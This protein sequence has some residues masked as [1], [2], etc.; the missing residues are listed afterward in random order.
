M[1]TIK[2]MLI[3]FAVLVVVL[4]AIPV[5]ASVNPPGSVTDHTHTEYLVDNGGDEFQLFA[6]S[7][8]VSGGT[9]YAL[10][11]KN[12]DNSFQNFLTS[13]TFGA[14]IG[15]A[16]ADDSEEQT[17][18]VAGALLGTMTGQYI[19]LKTHDDVPVVG[20]AWSW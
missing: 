15:I 6:I 9:Q 11:S 14:V 10:N 8:V 5:L 20:M 12:S 4:M 19:W 3:I 2:G 13:V 16:Q 1:K 17:A 7:G 18:A